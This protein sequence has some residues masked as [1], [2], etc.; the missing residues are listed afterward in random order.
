MH[1][2]ASIRDSWDAAARQDA[3]W[4]IITDPRYANGGWDREEFFAHGDREITDA[5]NKLDWLGVRPGFER[6]LDFGCGIGRLSVALVHHFV[7][8]DGVDIS[9]EMI[10][11][12]MTIWSP[13]SWGANPG[14]TRRNHY[15]HNTQPDLKLFE[16][17]TFDFVYSMIVLQHMPPEF[18][19]GYVREF[20]RVLKPGGV[21]MFQIPE[22]PTTG[23]PGHHLSMY[24]VSRETVESWIT[25]VADLVD[26]ENLGCEA[27]WTSLRYTATR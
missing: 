7:R 5:M 1:D 10:D 20:F 16:D 17:G 23:H 27:D 9:A 24:G 22:G 11:R 19:Q 13:K 3:M 4:N 15:H 6:A 21:A 8:V 12:A 26:V 18:Q 25:E 14:T 2:L